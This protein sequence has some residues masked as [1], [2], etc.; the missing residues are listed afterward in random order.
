MAQRYPNLSIVIDHGGKPEIARGVETAWQ[1]WA[2]GIAALAALPNV[3]C[4]LSGLLTE[5]GKSLETNI[6]KPWINEVLRLFGSERIM[7]GSDWPVLE[8]AENKENCYQT[9]FE[10]CQEI[11]THLTTTQK[12]SIFNNNAKRIYQL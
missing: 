12:D 2:D 3:S 6:C 5:A 8:L 10:Y 11:T 7:W 4:K 9:W 1:P